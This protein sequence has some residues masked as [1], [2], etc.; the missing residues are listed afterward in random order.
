MEIKAIEEQQKKDRLASLTKEEDKLIAKIEAL[1]ELNDE[2]MHKPE[3]ELSETTCQATT[4]KTQAVQQPLPDTDQKTENRKQVQEKEDELLRQ[5]GL[6]QIIR[7]SDLEDSIL[8]TSSLGNLSQLPASECIRVRSELPL[9]SDDGKLLEDRFTNNLAKEMETKNDF[10][11][12]FK[13]FKNF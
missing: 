8:L 3:Q 6:C 1:T 12:D 13:D 10:H 4:K 7:F 5:I 11:T 9:D 2:E